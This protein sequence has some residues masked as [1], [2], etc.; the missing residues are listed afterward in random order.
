M[1]EQSAADTGARRDR[2]SPNLFRLI[3]SYVLTIGI[4]VS[5]A[6][7]ALGFLLAILFGWR[8]SLAGGPP[9]PS[10]LADFGAM[11]A[12]LLA[13]RPAAITQ[14]GLGLLLATPVM[15]VAT[16]VVGFALEE[17][18]LYVVITL[19]VLAILLGSIFFIR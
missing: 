2:L 11:P 10:N 12:G 15:R 3:V 6:V 17:D 8:T 1:R 4:T 16:S 18:R 19:A 14:L 7:I 9:G 5:A 13:L